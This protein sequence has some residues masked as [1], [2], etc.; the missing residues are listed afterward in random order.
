MPAWSASLVVQV[1]TLPASLGRDTVHVCV[2]VCNR[3]KDREAV[4][5]C[6]SVTIE[7]HHVTDHPLTPP[8]WEKYVCVC[9][10]L[11]LHTTDVACV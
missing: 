10:L 3:E 8:L 6:P 11:W 9:G 7:V 2:H 5:A 1:R 4:C